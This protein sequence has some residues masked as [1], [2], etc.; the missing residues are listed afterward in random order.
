MHWIKD[1][2]G[3]LLPQEFGN[4][5]AYRDRIQITRELFESADFSDAQRTR[6]LAACIHDCAAFCELLE[7]IKVDTTDSVKNLRQTLESLP[8]EISKLPHAS[9]IEKLRNV[10]LHGHPLS[11]CAQGSQYQETNTRPTKPTKISSS[12][13]EAIMLLDEGR[14]K[15]RTFP[16]TAS[17]AGVEFGSAVTVTCSD[18]VIWVSEANQRAYQLPSVLKE[19]LKAAEELMTELS[20]KL[21]V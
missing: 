20:T 3:N 19:F 18:G 10:D 6:F 9:L 15:Q 4:L 17:E 14:L 21:G 16:K 1:K 11:P 5:R 7:I 8:K 2:N 12:G 13:P